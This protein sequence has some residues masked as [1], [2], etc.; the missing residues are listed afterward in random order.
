M[1]LQRDIQ[2]NQEILCH[3]EAHEHQLLP[4]TKNILMN[5]ETK[6]HSKYVHNIKYRKLFTLMPF[7]PGRP[8]YPGAPCFPCKMKENIHSIKRNWLFLLCFI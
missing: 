6:G 5:K 8:L 1:S 2:L 7:G 3:Q 4:A